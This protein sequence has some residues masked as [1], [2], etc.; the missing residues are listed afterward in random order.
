MLEVRTI[1]HISGP[2]KKAIK[3][4]AFQKPAISLSKTIVHLFLST[5]TQHSIQGKLLVI[6]FYNL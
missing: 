1:K 4:Q 3:G 2:M 6:Y 5:G